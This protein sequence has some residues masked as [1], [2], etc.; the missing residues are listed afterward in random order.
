MTTHLLAEV[1]N[2]WS[3]VSTP[4]ICLDNVDMENCKFTLVSPPKHTTLR[5]G[6]I[7]HVKAVVQTTICANTGNRTLD[8]PSRSQSIVTEPPQP[9]ANFVVF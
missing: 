1:K 9:I 8:S 7:S 5:S 6:S 4:P 2:E 3:H